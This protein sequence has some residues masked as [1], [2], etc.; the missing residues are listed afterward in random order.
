MRFHWWQGVGEEDVVIQ[1]LSFLLSSDSLVFSVAFL[2][3]LGVN[4]WLAGRG[5][6]STQ[7]IFM[8]Q[9]CQDYS[10]SPYSISQNGVICQWQRRL[11]TLPHCEP[12]RKGT[13]NFEN[14]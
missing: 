6:E 12:R 1:K 4:T 8:D 5:R 2:I 13:Y 3:S 14:N 7:V 10:F 11:E 9:L